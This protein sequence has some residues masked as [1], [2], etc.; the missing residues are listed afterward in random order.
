MN[1]TVSAQEKLINKVLDRD[2]CSACGACVGLC[3]YFAFF[4]GR[5]VVLDR[6]NLTEGRCAAFCPQLNPGDWLK[7]EGLGPIQ[8]SG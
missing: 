1:Q 7:Q 3:P 6:C 4:Q 8:E 5:V 2:L